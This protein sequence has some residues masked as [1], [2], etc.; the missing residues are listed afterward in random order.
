[1]TKKKKEKKQ[2]LGPGPVGLDIGT[3]NIIASRKE[4]DKVQSRRIRNAFLDLE[5]EAKNML[6]LSGVSFIEDG[7]KIVLLGDAALDMANLFKREARRPIEK[8]LISSSEMD[9]L[10]IL[11]ILIEN[12]IGRATQPGAVCFYS[13]PA[14]PVDAPDKDVTYHEAVF[15]RVI[16]DLG[17]TA[18]PGNE[19]MAIIYSECAKDM[20]SG[21]GVSMGSGMSNVAMAY[22]TMPVLEFSV[23]RGGDY[24]D[25][26]VA[27]ATGTTASRICAIKE[28]GIDLTQPTT[29]EE[30]ALVVYYRA[31]IDYVLRHI[32]Q[33][34]TETQR[35][36][37]L[38]KPIPIVVSGGTSLAKGF[39]E[40]FKEVFEEKHR[41]TFP[42]EISE[43]RHA[44][45]PLNAVSQGLLVQAIQETDSA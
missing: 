15:K 8:G 19:A 13:I 21:I 33:R 7:D 6:R 17:Y 39:V 1:M 40:V 3:M 4:G 38:G 37:E 31:H 32:A 20:F 42:I 24:I 14:A 11:S 30:E 25:S 5:A 29:R 18:M 2:G 27:Q 36:T 22:M 28:K 23:Q 16:E 41:K 26:A 34:F 9:A 12:V 44:E 45:D 10:G 35:D 43:I